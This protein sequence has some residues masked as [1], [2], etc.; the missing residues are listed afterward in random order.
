MTTPDKVPFGM[1]FCG[2]VWGIVGALF[3]H[4]A[5]IAD[6]QHSFIPYRSGSMSPLQAYA[7]GGLSLALGVGCC[8]MWFLRRRRNDI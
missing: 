8:I 2:I 6:Q 7:A 5:R 3:L 4:G 1:L